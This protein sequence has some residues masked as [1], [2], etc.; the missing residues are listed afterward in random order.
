MKSFEEEYHCMSRVDFEF[1]SEIE[2]YFFICETISAILFDA[3]FNILWINTEKIFHQIRARENGF[4]PVN[5][6]MDFFK[7]NWFCDSIL[8]QF[9]I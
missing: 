7:E 4:L 8:P 2:F 9:N 3:F 6:L 5:K 1:H